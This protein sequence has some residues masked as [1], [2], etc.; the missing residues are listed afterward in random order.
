MIGED[1]DRYHE[2]DDFLTFL[3]T[4]VMASLTPGVARAAGAGDAPIGGGPTAAPIPGLPVLPIEIMYM[5]PDGVLEQISLEPI[6]ERDR[7]LMF[8][9]GVE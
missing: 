4:W 8:D 5:R 2:P 6:E 1:G 9:P 7:R 3:R